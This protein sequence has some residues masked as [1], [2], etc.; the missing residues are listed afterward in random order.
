LD[1]LISVSSNVLSRE[2][3]MVA[4]DMAPEAAYERNIDTHIKAIRH[5]LKPFEMSERI[6][7]RRGFGYFYC[8]KGE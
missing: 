6:C 3:L 4:A 8:I 1:K 2:Q 5:K 7:T